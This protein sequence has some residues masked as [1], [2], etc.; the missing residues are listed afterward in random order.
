[1]GGFKG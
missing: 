1:M